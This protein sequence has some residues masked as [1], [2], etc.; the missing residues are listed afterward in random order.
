MCKLKWRN[1]CCAAQSGGTPIADIER[2]AIGGAESAAT[3]D[4]KRR[5]RIEA[6]ESHDL[7]I[8]AQ[9]RKDWRTATSRDCP[10]K[11]PSCRRGGKAMRLDCSSIET[12]TQFGRGS[13]SGNQIP[14]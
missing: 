4:R 11:E 1:A 3:L 8:G 14:S 6:S 2:P 10:H 9:Q 13:R 5:Y 12:G 7:L